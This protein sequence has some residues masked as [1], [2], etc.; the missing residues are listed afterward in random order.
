MDT[1]LGSLEDIWM[2]VSSAYMMVDV[3]LQLSGRS[4]MKSENR[5]GPNTEPWGTPLEIG[6]DV[7]Q[8]PLIDTACDR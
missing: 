5:N 8:Y 7:E 6:A 1:D 4:L 3:F 2:A